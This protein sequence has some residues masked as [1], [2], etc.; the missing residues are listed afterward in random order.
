MA[1]H[2]SILA[3]RIPGTEEPSGLLSMGLHRVGHDWSD[4]AA[5]AYQLIAAPRNEENLWGKKSILFFFKKSTSIPL[6]FSRKTLFL[7]YHSSS[8]WVNADQICRGFLCKKADWTLEPVR[9]ICVQWILKVPYQK[10]QEMFC[11]LCFYPPR[12]MHGRLMSAS[13]H[14]SYSPCQYQW[15]LFVSGLPGIDE[16]IDF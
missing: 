15:G 2:S 9:N 5:A 14:W 1:T 13:P 6:Q 4:L 16:V 12:G 11:P 3:W 8:C 7:K 10:F